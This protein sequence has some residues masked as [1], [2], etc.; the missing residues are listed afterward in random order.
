MAEQTSEAKAHEK[1]EGVMFGV[2]KL[3]KTPGWWDR[4]R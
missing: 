2:A 4:R 1:G 3:G